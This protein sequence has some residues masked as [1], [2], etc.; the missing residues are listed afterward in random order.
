MK[1]LS[2]M[3]SRGGVVLAVAGLG[4]ACH[5][6]ANTK[7]KQEK[8][9]I[10]VESLGGLLGGVGYGAAIF[11]IFTATP[12]GWVAAL[13]IGVGSVA[14]SYGTGQLIKNAYSMNGAHIDFA[15]LTKINTLCQ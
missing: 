10:L 1:N 7:N 4:V 2:R 11:V 13:A 8:N 12:I 15:S 9:E 14:T 5:Q 6:I 3:A